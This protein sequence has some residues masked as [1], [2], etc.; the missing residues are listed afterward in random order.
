MATTSAACQAI[1]MR[2]I[3]ED[4]QQKQK[5]ATTIFC[6]NLSTTAMTENLIHHN[7]KRH[8]DIQHH[9]IREHVTR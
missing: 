8:I 7:R 1:W 3:L 4:M 5:E 2:R 9:F 6:D